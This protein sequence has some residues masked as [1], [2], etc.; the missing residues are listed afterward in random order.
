[1]L[2]CYFANGVPGGQ[3]R[4]WI[5]SWIGYQYT[6]RDAY[7]ILAVIVSLMYQ[8]DVS[9]RICYASNESRIVE[10]YLLGED[11]WITGESVNSIL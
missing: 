6:T 4:M 9:H 2:V 1:M 11:I 7:M 5:A 10:L 8:S 3:I